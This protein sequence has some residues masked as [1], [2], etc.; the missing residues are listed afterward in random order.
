MKL[1]STVAASLLVFANADTMTLFNK[2][3][4]ALVKLFFQ[5]RPASG[6]AL[7]GSAILVAQLPISEVVSVVVS[8]PELATVTSVAMTRLIGYKLY[9]LK[10]TALQEPSDIGTCRRTA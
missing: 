1:T 9:L 5:I 2:L 7:T 4:E 3:S 8:M 6:G 10:G